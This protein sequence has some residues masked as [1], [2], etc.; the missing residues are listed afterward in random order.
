MIRN[1]YP[2]RERALG[3]LRG[4]YTGGLTGGRMA[5]HVVVGSGEDGMRAS[6]WEPASLAV[7]GQGA[8]P[9]SWDQ[10]GA[11]LLPLRVARGVNGCHSKSLIG[12]RTNVVNEALRGRHTASQKAAPLFLCLDVAPSQ[13]APAQ[14]ANTRHTARDEAFHGLLSSAGATLCSLPQWQR[15]CPLS[16][17]WT[18]KP[19]RAVFLALSLL[20]PS[21]D[22]C[23]SRR[24]LVGLPCPPS[25][26]AV[27]WPAR[28]LAQT[29]QRSLAVSKHSTP[30]P[31]TAA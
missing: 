10:A 12:R 22:A 3:G 1:D 21:T 25:T 16:L 19:L 31:H 9:C 15:C 18:E 14:N 24:L 27:R 5:R 17:S 7:T 23:A 11:L 13:G 20:P 28:D 26:R 4:Q 30:A 6:M 8:L 2:R 29:S